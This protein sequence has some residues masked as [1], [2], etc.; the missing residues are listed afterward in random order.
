[1][2]KLQRRHKIY[3]AVGLSLGLI[4]AALGN[5]F[6]GLL[7]V[8]ATVFLMAPEKVREWPNRPSFWLLFAVITALLAGG[9]QN[10]YSWVVAVIY[11]G[12]AVYVYYRK[13]ADT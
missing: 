5:Y 4:I 12:V 9:S 8:S 7:I 3:L 6:L 1:M 11:L 13:R 2:G 10:R